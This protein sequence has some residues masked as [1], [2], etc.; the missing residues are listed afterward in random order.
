MDFGS[1]HVDL[2]RLPVRPSTRP[3][4]VPLRLRRRQSL[5][6]R[7]SAG[8]ESHMVVNRCSG[9]GRPAQH[10]SGPLR[11]GGCPVHRR[12]LAKLLQGFYRRQKVLKQV[13]KLPELTLEM[14][15]RAHLG[16][17]TL[18]QPAARPCK[19]HACPYTPFHA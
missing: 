19:D 8:K 10:L 15:L 17:D 16:L 4:P 11:R 2:S 9:F 13:W 6:P 14:S 3:W 18:A 12:R 5:S 7:P 1:V